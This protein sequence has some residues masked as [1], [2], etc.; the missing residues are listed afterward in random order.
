MLR[1]FLLFIL[2]IAACGHGAD[3]HA[4]SGSAHHDNNPRPFNETRD[5][6]ADVD[7]ALASAAERNVNALLIL[8]GNW[9]HDSR[10]LAAKFEQPE[11]ASIIAERFSLVWVDVGHRDRNLD[12]AQ[13]FGVETLLGTPTV[14]IVSP[15]GALLNAE[16]VHDWRTADSRPYEDA[17]EYFSRYAGVTP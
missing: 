6:H 2:L 14:L 15:G 1:L 3:H 13:R 12:V 5:A 10:G 16:S 4:G 11:L 9:C 17:L 8:G 7:A